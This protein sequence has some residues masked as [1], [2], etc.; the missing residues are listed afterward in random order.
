MTDMAMIVNF[1]EERRD[2]QII[3][4]NMGREDI[5]KLGAVSPIVRIMWKYGGK[6]A[7]VSNDYAI[8]GRV[9][10]GRRFVAAALAGDESRRCPK[11][12]IYNPDGTLRHMLSSPQLIS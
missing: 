9:V 7:S 10:R 2:G 5:K 11:L 3:T 1:E 4:E 8:L 6:V 12:G